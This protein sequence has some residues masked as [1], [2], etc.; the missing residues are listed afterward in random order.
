MVCPILLVAVAV[1]VF[2]VP[3]P[4]RQKGDYFT[5]RL[6][7]MRF[8]KPL[9]VIQFEKSQKDS[10]CVIVIIK[11]RSTHHKFQTLTLVSRTHSNS[12]DPNTKLK[13]PAVE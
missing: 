8:H 4:E 5:I 3:L 2:S 1:L 13:L 7:Q 12:V 9:E 6:I 11:I 10:R